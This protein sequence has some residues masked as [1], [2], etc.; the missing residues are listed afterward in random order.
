ML[1]LELATTEQILQEL[2]RRPVR[3]VFVSYTA[4]GSERGSGLLAHS[5]ELADDE[6]LGLLKQAEEFFVDSHD[7]DA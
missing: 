3:F 6:A 1:E 4:D 7:D 5:P 2:A